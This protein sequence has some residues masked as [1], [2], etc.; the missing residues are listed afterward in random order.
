MDRAEGMKL[1]VV[2]QR[3]DNQAHRDSNSR[4]SKRKAGATPTTPRDHEWI[5]NLLVRY[6]LT[7][8]WRLAVGLRLP[9]GISPGRGV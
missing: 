3:R 8:I 7:H 6:L 4:L 1:Y 9:I 2:T 5:A